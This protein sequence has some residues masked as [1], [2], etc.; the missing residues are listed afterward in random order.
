M[1]YEARAVVDGTEQVIGEALEY[2][3]ILA[4]GSREAIR[5]GLPN[6][7]IWESENLTPRP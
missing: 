4:T 3:T 7:E 1:L 2:L 5:L 6:F